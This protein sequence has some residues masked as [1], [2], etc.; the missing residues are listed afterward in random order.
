MAGGKYRTQGRM[1]EVTDFLERDRE[2]ASVMLGHLVA[3]R[4]AGAYGLVM[5]ELVR[6]EL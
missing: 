3:N 5:E 4:T 2:I 6:G 1:A